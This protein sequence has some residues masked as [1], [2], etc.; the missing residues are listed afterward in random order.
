M[1]SDLCPLVVLV[2]PV[3]CLCVCMHAV[4]ARLFASLFAGLVAC[5]S[6]SFVCVFVFVVLLVRLFVWL[7]P[8][9]FLSAFVL[10]FVS[11]VWLFG[12]QFVFDGL[13]LC[14]CVGSCLLL[15]VV[16]FR[17]CLLG[18]CLAFRLSVRMFV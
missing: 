17:V 8:F 2:C 13:F 1:F 6:C 7:R 18:V 14:L 16:R 9:V 4:S 15:F 10:L 3:G 12:C 5:C 11:F